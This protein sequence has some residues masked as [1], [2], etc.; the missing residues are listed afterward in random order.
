MR[1]NNKV[2]NSRARVLK[3]QYYDEHVGRKNIRKETILLYEIHIILIVFNI[4]YI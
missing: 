1:D 3:N 2:K 4:D